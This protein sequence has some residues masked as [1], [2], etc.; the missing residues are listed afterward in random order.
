MKTWTSVALTL[1]SLLILSACQRI[2]PT[3]TLLVDGQVYTLAT[4]SQ[5]LPTEIL[6][7]AGITLGANDR[8]LFLGA[9]IPLDKPLP[10]AASYT[11]SVRRAVTLTLIT[12]DGTQT[13][14]TS[15]LTVGQALAETGFKLYAA[16]RSDPPAETP[17]TA[18]LTVTF[19]PSRR[20]VV[21]ADGKQVEVRSAAPKVGQALAEAGIPLV[22]LD[23]AVPSETSPLPEDGL[24]RIVQV[25]ESVALTLKTIPFNTRTEFSADLEIDHS[26][27]LQ[28]GEPG[29]AITRL[30]TRSE[31]GLQVSQESESESIVRPPQ[32]RILGIGTKIVIRT[33][34]VDGETITY[35]RALNLY[36]TYF[37]PLCIPGDCH[38]N[39]ATGKPVQKGMVAF[40]Y[41][42][43]L[44]FAHE[45]LYVPGYGFATVEDNNG[46]N[47]TA[48]G[49]Y[50]IDLGYSLTDTVDWKNQYVTVYF[51]TPVAANVADTYTLP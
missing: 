7:D 13:F 14:Q 33:A 24:I 21:I 26:E 38:P 29:L 16:D 36:A 32:D 12:P 46:A 5:R 2:N 30:R 47:T 20:L 28:G 50:W 48:M 27:L 17:I 44:L 6:S 42:W 11:L 40:V 37:I 49:T 15:A 4:P 1:I 10:Q 9:P 35:W 45:H 25:V 3:V 23:Y 34:V 51:L 43:F 39:T 22:G 41:P 18:A 8:L 31:D 19:Q